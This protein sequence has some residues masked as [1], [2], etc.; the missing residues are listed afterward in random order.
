MGFSG[1][2]F[3]N[4]IFLPREAKKILFANR[5]FSD[6]VSIWDK[7][8]HNFYA[9][10]NLMVKLYENDIHGIPLLSEKNWRDIEG[11]FAEKSF[12]EPEEALC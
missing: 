9:L 5:S 10:D 7:I 3:T 11:F 2:G 1:A 6:L 8:L 4:S 12:K